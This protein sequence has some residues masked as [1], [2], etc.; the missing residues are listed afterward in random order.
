MSQPGLY[1][2]SV[3][4]IKISPGIAA[5]INPTLCSYGLMTFKPP[6]APGFYHCTLIG[7]NKLW[8]NNLSILFSHSGIFGERLPLRYYLSGGMLLSGLFTALF[9]LGYYWN[10]HQLWYFVFVQVKTLIPFANQV[11]SIFYMG[12]AGSGQPSSNCAATSWGIFFIQ[13]FPFTPF[14]PSTIKKERKKNKQQRDS[15]SI[16]HQE[17]KQ[18]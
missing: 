9:G 12:W 6:P 4:L 7:G 3:N 15:V 17:P 5:S 8:F 2:F 11:L 1:G 16:S 10:I 13:G 18:V 14:P